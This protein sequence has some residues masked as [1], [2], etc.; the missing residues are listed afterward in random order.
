M[1]VCGD[2]GRV[3]GMC[4]LDKGGGGWTW[5]FVFWSERKEE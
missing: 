1:D 3:K 5:A 4:V 2:R